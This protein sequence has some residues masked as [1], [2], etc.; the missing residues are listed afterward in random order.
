MASAILVLH[1]LPAELQENK[2][3]LRDI[4]ITGE[5]NESGRLLINSLF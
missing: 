5:E 3:Q 1:Q 4:L 2:T